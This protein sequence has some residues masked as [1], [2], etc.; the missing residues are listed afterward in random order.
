MGRVG[1]AQA[2][3]ST[4]SWGQ[5]PEVGS[6]GRDGSSG[7]FSPLPCL[8]LGTWMEQ[9]G[10]DS[11][12][13]APRVLSGQEEGNPGQRLREVSE[14]SEPGGQSSRGWIELRG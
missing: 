11:V 5:E 9:Q 6:A 10:G 14:G 2:Q 12:P 4:S 8:P 3:K 7:H 1:V 13:C